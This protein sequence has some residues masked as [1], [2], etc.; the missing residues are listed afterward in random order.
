MS[1]PLI[2]LLCA[3]L[4][5]LGAL[6]IVIAGVGILR[7]P[8][9]PTRMH[10]SSKAAT[11]GTAL[12]LL[13][14]GI[15]FGEAAVLVRTLL[16]VLFLLVTAPVAAHMIARAGYRGGVPLAEDT[17]LDEYRPTVTRDAAPRD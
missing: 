1:L 10:A 4:A 5:G 6:L 2:P 13:A 8:D 3:I 15:W 12:I 16:I 11:L 14:V 17:A 7:M 9:L